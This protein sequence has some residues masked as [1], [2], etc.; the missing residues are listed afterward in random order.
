MKECVFDGCFRESESLGLCSGHYQQK[1]RG[2]TLSP[3]SVRKIARDGCLFPGCERQHKSRG[4]CNAH[5]M[6]V[7]I[8][9]NEPAEIQ[10]TA[11]GKCS[12]EDC[13]K[14]QKSKGLCGSHYNQKRRGLELRPLQKRSPGEWGEWRILPNGY[15][16]RGITLNGKKTNQLQHR[17]VMSEHIGRELLPHETVHHLNGVRDDNRIENL[18]LWSKSQPAGQRV[19]DKTAWA[20]E[21]LSEYGYQVIDPK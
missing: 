21:F 1:R 4:W 18:E 20:K 2:K 3:L 12:F 15:V 13:E 16:S 5:Y 10:K 7:I 6:Q 11:S 17:L 9:G 8:N 19:E 14:G